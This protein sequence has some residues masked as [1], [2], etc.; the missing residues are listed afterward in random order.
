VAMPPTDGWSPCPGGEFGQLARRLAVRRRRM[1]AVTIFAGIAAAGATAVAATA[2]T[3]Y[4]VQSTTG[5]QPPAGSCG[6]PAP[7]AATENNGCSPIAK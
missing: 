2:V 6:S 7:A 3:Q 4:V 1:M 5:C